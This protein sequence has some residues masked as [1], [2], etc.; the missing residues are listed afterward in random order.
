MKTKQLARAAMASIGCSLALGA[1][2][3]GDKPMKVIVPAPPG[4][5]MDIV[6][7]VVGQQMAIDIGRPVIV[8][9]R[10]GAGGVD[11]TCR[12]CCKRRARRQHDRDGGEQRAGRNAARDEDALRPAEGRACPSPGGALGRGAGDRR[13]LPGQGLPG[14]R[15]PTE[16]AQGPG[17]LRQLQPG[18]VVALRGTD[19]QRPGRAGHAARGLSRLAARAAGP[20]GRPGRHDVRRHA[21]LRAADQ[22]AASCAPMPSAGKSA[23][24]AICPTCR[25]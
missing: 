8:E 13:H 9:N 23:L 7:R 11:R 10:A 17:Q 4:G 16:D 20:A 19:P 25:P 24:A 22:G 3:F 1:W 6:A 2:A 5:T 18:T 14:P 12:P 21:D 15:R